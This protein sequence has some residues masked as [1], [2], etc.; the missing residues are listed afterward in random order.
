MKTLHAL[1]VLALLQAASPQAPSSSPPAA[2]AN[3]PPPKIEIRHAD[4]V[5]YDGQNKLIQLDG[6]VHI[7]RLTMSIK[8]DH[9]TILLTDD[10]KRVKKAIATG[11][12]DLED[13]DRRGRSERA[14]FIESSQDIILTGDPKLVN[15]PNEMQADSI[16]YN[17]NS[18][19]MRAAGRVR[20][21]LVPGASF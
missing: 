14:E 20:G 18:R 9:V 1:F 6:S 19:T 15:G 12:V 21:I 4:T 8:A 11:H 3:T 10:E 2:N 5:D 17:L 7:V 16:V 13:G